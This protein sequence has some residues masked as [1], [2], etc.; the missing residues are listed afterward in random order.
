MSQRVVAE[1]VEVV[2]NQHEITWS[3]N[4]VDASGGTGQ[5]NA[6][7]P[8]RSS[9]AHRDSG[10]KSAEPLVT[11]PTPVESQNPPVMPIDDSEQAGMAGYFACREKRLVGI[12]YFSE[13]VGIFEG[14]S[15]A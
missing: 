2:R 6:G 9:Q 10:L 15:P 7:H 14:I 3:K 4:R 8:E 12:A 5:Y 13:T 11:V 1:E